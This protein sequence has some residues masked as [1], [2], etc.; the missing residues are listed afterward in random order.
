[1]ESNRSLQPAGPPPNGTNVTRKN[2]LILNGNPAPNSFT[3]AICDAYASSAV[4]AA[5]TVKRYNVRDLSFN[6][7]LEH[8]YTKRTPLEPD[9]WELMDA[10]RDSHHLVLAFPVWWGQVPAPLK[11]LLDRVLLPGFAFDKHE[12][13][14]WWDAHLN[15]RSARVIHTLDQP[16]WFY[17]LRFGAPTKRSIGAMTL[18]FVGYKPVRHTFIGPLRKSSAAW[19]EKQLQHIT[20]LGRA[21]R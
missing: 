8:G 4:A 12:N 10:I 18:G 11:G 20:K 15:G 16:A 13:D 3:E 21:L 6:P 2:V 14:P 9:L 1:M 5:G 17:R 19:R 7:V